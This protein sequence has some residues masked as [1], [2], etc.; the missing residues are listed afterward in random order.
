MS[1]YRVLP[2]TAHATAARQSGATEALDTLDRLQNLQA[3]DRR[4]AAG[5]GA[6]LRGNG[7]RTGLKPP[8]PCP[9]RGMGGLADTS[10]NQAFIWVTNLLVR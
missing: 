1:K 2:S 7:T 5:G 9:A 10:A 8:G 6:K 4:A 3:L